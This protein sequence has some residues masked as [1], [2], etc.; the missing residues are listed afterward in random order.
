[1]SR[2]LARSMFKKNAPKRSAKGVG[3]TS[4][5]DDAPGYAEGGEVDSER[6]ERERIARSLLDRGR[7]E[8]QRFSEGER[9]QMTRPPATMPAPPQM[10]P[11]QMQ[12]AQMQQLAQM[13]MLPRFQEGGVVDASAADPWYQRFLDRFPSAEPILDPNT[14]EPVRP[15]DPENSAADRYGMTAADAAAAFLS[16]G[17]VRVPGSALPGSPAMPGRAPGGPTPPGPWSMDRSGGPWSPPIPI[18]RRAPN[19]PTPPT[20]TGVPQVVP[21]RGSSV[22]QAG[23]PGLR[24]PPTFADSKLP[25]RYPNFEEVPQSEDEKAPSTQGADNLPPDRAPMRSE[26]AEEE[27][28]RR[29][30]AD[31][32]KEARK[33]KAGAGGAGAPAGQARPKTTELQE[34]KDGRRE[35]AWLA[36]MQAGLSMASGQSSNALTNIAQGAQAGLGSFVGLEKDR[37]EEER[38][39][40]ELAVRQ[41]MADREFGLQE[42]KMAL[43]APLIQAQTQLALAR[44]AMAAEAARNRQLMRETQAR[45]SAG[46]AWNDYAK[47]NP[48]YATPG[49][50]T[51][52]ARDLFIQ[53]ETMRLLQQP[54]GLQDPL[55]LGLDTTPGE[56]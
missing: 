30:K 29:A 49:P 3:I 5:F 24:K 35:N 26:A 36:L 32:E 23:I 48:K 17:R 14:M 34:I 45:E 40:R 18:G 16:R 11:Q 28:A 44:P 42:R 19:A 31:K 51:D 47:T 52:M 43:Q 38:R 41:A 50:A 53:R 13:G 9:P 4:M 15:F 7:E 56:D 33:E 10:S 54:S 12:A 27:R 37:R 21:P 6:V 39:Q 2:V 55:G 1:M 25:Y 46:K 8:Y 20:G 22:P